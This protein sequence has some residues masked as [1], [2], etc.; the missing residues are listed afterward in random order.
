MFLYFGGTSPATFALHSF[1]RNP[2]GIFGRI[3]NI[4]NGVGSA[5]AGIAKPTVLLGGVDESDYDKLPDSSLLNLRSS[6][7]APRLLEYRNYSDSLDKETTNSIGRTVRD[8]A[9]SLQ[10]S[11]PSTMGILG[12]CGYSADPLNSRFA[13]HFPYPAGGKNPRS[14]RNLL[15]DPR[16]KERGLVHPINDRINLACKIASA[17]LYVHSCDLVHKNIRPANI[18]IFEPDADP[19]VEAAKFAQYPYAVGEP[20]LVGFEGIR[21]AEAASQRLEVKDWEQ[22]IY[23]PPERHRLAAG[24]EFT[25]R[26]DIYSLGV[27]LLEI[28]MW[29]AFTDRKGIGQRLWK[30]TTTTPATEQG[31]AKDRLS[32]LTPEALQT[33]FLRIANSQV[34]RLLGNKYRDVVIACLTGLRYEEGEHLLDDA[35]GLVVGRAYITRVMRKLEDISV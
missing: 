25:M 14:L 35:D 21:K 5:A 2:T 20:Y 26:H 7:E 1:A 8:L 19:N 4:R 12:C 17:V 9:V 34:P 18:L 30:K 10:K 23:L 24:D 27:V 32:I 31:V 13:L 29:S 28:A 15:T 22:N 33:E 6:A 3:E 16:N 11:D